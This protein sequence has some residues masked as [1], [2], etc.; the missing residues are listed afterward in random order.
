MNTCIKPQIEPLKSVNLQIRMDSRMDILIFDSKH[1]PRPCC[2]VTSLDGGYFDHHRR[3]WIC[4]DHPKQRRKGCRFP[5]TCHVKI[6]RAVSKTYPSILDTFTF[7]PW[8]RVIP[9]TISQAGMDVFRKS[10]GRIWND[11]LDPQTQT[12]KLLRFMLILAGNI[13]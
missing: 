9:L 10:M 3:G 13:L 5:S 11:R 4:A 7:D 8:P 6:R 12:T 1:R 2:S